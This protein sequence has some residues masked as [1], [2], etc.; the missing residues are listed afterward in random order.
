[1]VASSHPWQTANPVI[2]ETDIARVK[3]PARLVVFGSSRYLDAV[4]C[5]SPPPPG[6]P[7][8]ADVDWGNVELRPP[9]SGI[10]DQNAGIGPQWVIHASGDMCP[11]KIWP[12][13]GAPA[14]AFPAGVPTGRWGEDNIPVGHLDGST[15]V[16][17]RYE[18]AS[19]MTRWSPKA[20][21]VR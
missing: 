1:V 16:I 19:D 3:N 5:D 20:T 12:A 4:D 13:A 15:E 10:D 11:G 21:G 6:V 14:D 7:N 18:L 2:A 17:N 8:I 9:F